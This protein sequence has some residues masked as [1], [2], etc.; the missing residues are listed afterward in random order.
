MGGPAHQAALLSGRRFHPDRYETLLVHGRIPE[1]ERSAAFLSEREGA[2]M[3]YLPTL[4]QPISPVYDSRAIASLVKLIRGFRPDI[5]HTHTAK[6]GFMGRS[7]IVAAFP[8]GGRPKVVHT[9]H[10]HV[11]EG[12]FGPG[13]A[14]LYRRLETG[15]A[16][17]TD[18]LIGVSEATIDDLVRLGVA[19]REKFTRVPLGLDLDAIAE[20]A[21]GLRERTRSDLG[22]GEAEVACIFVGRIAP[23]KRVDRLL[24]AFAGAYEQ[25]PRLRLLVVGDGPDRTEL[26]A[27][28]RT[29]G[30]ANRVSW[31]GYRSDLDAL[32]A[33]AD[34]GVLSSDNEGTPVSLIEAGAA[35]LPA[36]ATDVGGVAE[37]VEP[38]CGAVVP[39]GDT[40]AISSA[41]AELARDDGARIAAGERARGRI[42]DT[43]SYASLRRAIDGIYS[44]LLGGGSGAASPDSERDVRIS[45]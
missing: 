29:L 5:V 22:I 23:I 37:V 16:R 25:V 19:P 27:R 13:R 4:I 24:D 38:G 42:L 36:V 10:G 31:L 40:A 39:A 30:I 21:D 9:F 2:T 26:E 11:L 41:L 44:E 3:R 6:A 45:A 7:A 17:V 1:G 32:F 12:Y 18:R 8:R 43:Y 28:A 33:A 20:P 35:G 15:L 14:A 34:L